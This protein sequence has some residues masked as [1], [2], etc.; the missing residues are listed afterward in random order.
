VK[1]NALGSDKRARL[2]AYYLPQFHPIPENDAWWG[3]GFTEW[4]NVA[5]AKPLFPSHYQPRIPADLGF[6]DLR[7][8]ETRIAQAE[9]AGAYGIEGFCYYHYWFAGRQMLSRPL[10]EV[11]GSGQPRFPF[12]VCW[13]NE[14]W[15]G[16]WSGDDKR[17][18]LE[19]TY[20]GREDEVAH[21]HALVGAFSDDRY[22]CIEGRPVF[23]VYQPDNLP[24]PRKWT[25]TWR[26]LAG[27]A[28]LNGLYLVAH[29]NAP[30]PFREMGFDASTPKILGSIR[31]YDPRWLRLAKTALRT[32]IGF[33]PWVYSYRRIVCGNH[34]VFSEAMN[35]D[36]F[37]CVM[38]NWDNTP[39]RGKRGLVIHNSTPDLFRLHVRRALGQVL[40]KPTEKRVVFV[41]S[42]NEWA[43]GNYLEPDLKFGRGYL[44]A[45][46]AE[47]MT[48]HSL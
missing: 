28:G 25:D 13:A 33:P 42:W 37:P 12:C 31:M 16:I 4:T 48:E 1:T 9:M 47:I 17:I 6:Y 7:V 38:P 46:R 24:D 10:E 36:V 18:L 22:I 40:H 5:S 35:D 20:P 3:R 21:F 11:L 26:E 19:Q 39:R 34:A 23:V 2:I 29:T 43:E 30:W 41:K 8:S 32:A 15:T 14:H 44:D 45:L 27:R